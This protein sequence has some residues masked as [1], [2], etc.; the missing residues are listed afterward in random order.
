MLLLGHAAA[1]TAAP[2]GDTFNEG[3][4]NLVGQGRKPKA[5]LARSRRAL[6][7]ASAFLRH[8]RRGKG[9]VV[10]AAAFVAKQA[11]VTRAGGVLGA[12]GGCAAR[13]CGYEGGTASSGGSTMDGAA[14]GIS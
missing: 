7:A 3:I 1:L 4:K 9:V 8:P 13:G 12:T 2:G 11:A 6:D 14:S 5:G 10:S